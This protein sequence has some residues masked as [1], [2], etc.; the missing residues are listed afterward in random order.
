[1]PILKITEG[2]IRYNA[3]SQSIARGETYY[4]NPK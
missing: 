4:S 3:S 1:M 2:A